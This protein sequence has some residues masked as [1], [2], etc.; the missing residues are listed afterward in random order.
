MDIHFNDVPTGLDHL[1]MEG[2][3]KVFPVPFSNELNIVV[4]NIDRSDLS[5]FIYDLS[6]REI[7]HNRFNHPSSSYGWDAKTIDGQTIEN[8]IYFVSI[9]AG[10][11]K[12][13]YKKI[14]KIN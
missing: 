10:Y 13:Y 11:R 8:G 2:N 1:P 14:L 9:Q 3:I 7:F 12:I 5:F 6:G 4:E